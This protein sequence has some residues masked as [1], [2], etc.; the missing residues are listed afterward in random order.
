M[1]LVNVDIKGLGVALVI[2]I[3]LAII[4]GYIL[5]GIADSIPEDNPLRERIGSAGTTLVTLAIIVFIILMVA[6]IKRMLE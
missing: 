3:I 2:F 1:S 6:L 5:W 4:I